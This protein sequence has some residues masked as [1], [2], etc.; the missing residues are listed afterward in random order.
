MPRRRKSPFDR[1]ISYTAHEDKHEHARAL[2]AK[3][4]GSHALATQSLNEVVQDTLQC[5]DAVKGPHSHVV[6]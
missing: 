5:C 2:A 3:R 4:D 1:H 6:P